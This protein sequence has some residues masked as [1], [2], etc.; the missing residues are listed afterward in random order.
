VLAGTSAPY[1]GVQPDRGILALCLGD[2][3]YRCVVQPQATGS[4]QAQ[5]A[6]RQPVPRHQF[7]NVKAGRVV[8]ALAGVMAGQRRTD[9]WPGPGLAPEYEQPHARDPGQP[10][11]IGRGGGSI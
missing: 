10:I 9:A 6:H 8:S 2:S 1:S 11:S 3:R 5:A 7:A 4:V